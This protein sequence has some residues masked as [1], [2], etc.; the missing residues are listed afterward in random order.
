[1]TISESKGRFFLLQNES[2]RTDSRNESNRIDSESRIGMLYFPVISHEDGCARRG[3]CMT[4]GGAVIVQQQQQLGDVCRAAFNVRRHV[5][6]VA[7]GR[8]L[9][10]IGDGLLFL[11]TIWT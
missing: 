5:S 3:N 10:R 8:R 2:I 1:M 6:S 9:T 7:L 11:H 4:L